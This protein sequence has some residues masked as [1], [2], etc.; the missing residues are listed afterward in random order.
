M[1]TFLLIFHITMGT[2]GIISG[3]CVIGIKKGNAL[4]KRIGRVFFITMFF[5]GLSGCL[6]AWVKHIPLSM[7]NGGL[8]CYLVLSAFMAMRR[9][10]AALIK[11]SK[12]L[13]VFGLLLVTGYSSYFYFALGASSTLNGGFGPSAFAVFG[14]I[15]VYALGEDLCYLLSNRVSKRFM[16]IRHL[17]RMLFPLFMASAAVFLGQAK[18]FPVLLVKNGVLIIPVAF[19]LLCLFYWVGKTWVQKRTS[20]A[21]L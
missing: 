8:V 7:L 13:F 18:H 20:G 17:W 1:L 19:V 10:T 3:F 6:V 9:N 12:G 11:L 15:T 2:I 5:M 16:L 14:L 21:L 4:H